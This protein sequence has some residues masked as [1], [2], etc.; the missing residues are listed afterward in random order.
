[1]KKT[2]ILL[3]AAIILC[4][5]ASANKEDNNIM[6]GQDDYKRLWSKVDSL[7]DKGLPASVLK[8]LDEIYLKA[9]KENEAAQFVKAVVFKLRYNAYKQDDSPAFGIEQLI[10]E[11]ETAQFPIKPVL[12]SMLADLYAQ[13]YNNNRWRFSERSRTQDFD[14]KDIRTWDLQSLVEQTII[15]HKKALENPEELKKIKIDL[16][17][18]VIYKGYEGRLFRP[19]L[20]DFLAHKA[21]DYFM[22]SEPD[23][24]HPAEQFNLNDERYFSPAEEFVKIKLSTAD[25]LSYK[26]YALKLLQDMISFH[27]ADSDLSPLTD[28]DL[29]RLDFV[30]NNAVIEN[31]EH[32]YLNTISRLEQKTISLPISTEVSYRIA[33]RSY[34]NSL[35]YIAGVSE[36]HRWDAKI[37]REMCE[38]IID[39]FP[40]SKGAQDC[41]SLISTIETK[42]MNLVYEEVNVPDKPFLGQLKFRNMKKVYFRVIKTSRQEIQSIRK[43][44]NEYYDKHEEWK[45]YDEILI[46][47]YNKKTPLHSFSYTLPDDGDFQ[48]HTAEVKV[49]GLSSGEYLIM[50]A[51]SEAF[52]YKEQAVCFAFT[53]SNSIS[54]IYR[55]DINRDMDF[56]VMHRETGKHLEA[57]SAKLSYQKYDYKLGKYV[58]MDGGI[59]KTD[60]QGYFQVKAPKEYRSFNLEFRYKNEVYYTGNDDNNNSVFYQ[61]EKEE[62]EILG[63]PVTTFFLDRAIYRPGQTLYFKGICYHANGKNTKILPNHESTVTLYD[64]N[65]QEVASVAVT[66]NEFGTFNGSFVLPNSGLNGQMSINNYY[67]SASFSVEDYK[68]PKF[69]VKIDK[70]KGAYRLNDQVSITGNAKAYS[71]ANIDGA[72]V[73]FRVVRKIN[74]PDWWWYY[75]GSNEQTEIL[76]GVVKTNEKGEFTIS[77]KALPDPTVSASSQAYFSYTVYADVTDINGETRSSSGIVRIGYTTLQVSLDIPDKLEKEQEN[78]FSISSANLDGEYQPAK[79]KLTIYR[80]KN[81]GRAFR[82]KLWDNPDKFLMS[83]EEFYAA[84]PHDQY[85]DEGDFHKWEKEKVSDQDFDTEANKK[86]AL[87]GMKAWPQGMYLAELI[88]K[89]KFGTEVKELRYFTLF[90]KKEAKL[91]YPETDWFVNLKY[92]AE[93][94]EKTEI[95][96]GSSLDSVVVLYEVEQ[97][98]KLLSKKIMVLNNEQKFLQENVTENF[99]GNFSI[100]YTFIK[101]NRLY[102]HDETIV[103]PYTNKELEITFETFR[104]KLQPGEAEE[105][106]IK[107]KGKMGDKVAAEMAATLYDASLDVFRPNNWSFNIYPTY[108]AILNWDN[109]GSG[110]STS[111][112]T[113]YQVGWY[114]TQSGGYRSYDSFNWFGYYYSGYDNGYDDEDEVVRSGGRDKKKSAKRLTKDGDQDMTTVTEIQY[115]T[116]S[117]NFSVE[118]KIEIGAKL[119]YSQEKEEAKKDSPK[120]DL[121]NIK[122]RTNFNET[123][124]FFPDL[125]TDSSGALVIKFKIPEALTRWKMLGFAHTRDLKFGLV[126]KELITQKELMVV[127]NAPRFFREG[128]KISFSSKITNL[129]DKDL[130][131]TVQLMLFDALTMKPADD[132]MGNSKAQQ[133]FSA[134]A[135]QSAGVFWDIKIPEGMQAVTY[136]VVAKAGKFSDGEEMTLPVLT[137][138]MLMTESMPMPIRSKQTKT[139]TLDKMVHNKSATLR[140]HKLTLEFTSQPAWYAIQALPYLMEYP[141]ECAEQ[142]FSRFYANSIATHI[143]N[144]DPKIK[145]V[146]DSWQ[147][148]TSDALLSNLEKNQELKSLMLEETP[149]VRDA[150]G[151][152]E[153]KKRIAVLFDL[154]RMS[155][156]LDRALE[157]ITR[158]Q[159]ANGA[160]PWFEGMPEDRYITQH[161]TTGL[162][163]LDHLGIKNIR[164]SSKTWKMAQDA[165]G[166]LDNRI[167]KDYEELKALEARKLI[168]LSDNNLSYTQI[169]YLYMRSFFRDVT[170]D[171][172]NQEAV[173]YFTRQSKKYWLSFN[174]YMQGMIALALSRNGETVVTADIIKSMREFA[175]ISDEMGMYW[176]QDYGYFWYQA[177]IETQSLMVEVFNEVAKD[178]KAVD[179]LKVWLIKNKQTTD[180]KTTKATADACYALLL[181]GINW[182]ASDELV[183]IKVGDM[184]IDPGKM[185]DV[186]VEAGTGYFKTSWN[187][188]EIKPEMGTV[189]LSKKD[190]GVSWGA[191][192]WQYFEQLDKITPHETPLKLKKQ[193]FL[194]K[195]T[196]TGPVIV[197]VTDKTELKPGDLIK[198]RIELRVDRTMEYV[199]MKDM[200]ASAFE[201][202]NVMSQYKY[203][204]GL[205][206]YESTRDAATNF[207]FGYLPKGTYVFQYPL[208]VTHDGD[209]SNGVTT[210]QCMYAPEFIS[211]SEGLRVK[212]GK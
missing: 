62:E 8:V 202:V 183:E 41:R 199:H 152:T 180:W 31:K 162:G 17:D 34:D 92:S 12:H 117:Y 74:F 6:L 204:D 186:K 33:Y 139:F 176:K 28:V 76:N 109:N 101:N 98:G 107:I 106:R 80:L 116:E 124:F 70:V 26:F 178:Q 47:H 4:C 134:K 55:T 110:F 127:P 181:T 49:P 93:P 59:F 16:Y 168:K 205:G 161:I 149:W 136:R 125:R 29:K 118:K 173:N 54:Y 30:F 61:Y 39:R 72:D 11:S 5:K 171:K 184:T 170:I 166:Y 83:R 71:G 197:P 155:M 84:F 195:N 88:S 212:V 185:P 64:V 15:Q 105:W 46:D 21:I 96:A 95:L 160:W 42:N 208:R 65:G 38:K 78:E 153:R 69:E 102:R 73:K 122:A 51:S 190:E 111:A 56:H 141:Y 108:Y 81:P 188:L 209:F 143:V 115:E 128:D 82:A 10:A 187:G 44:A 57:V 191:L 23:V 144:S 207:F 156:E 120:E 79:G 104:D 158:M 100:H 86:L 163:H 97:F 182:L 146:F 66:A 94:G 63:R 194:E 90:S 58:N 151:E 203:Q 99:R 77:F 32:L 201:P 52:T 45:E 13:Y 189:V 87:K 157:K 165:L 85:S 135:G 131:G 3:V 25:S 68:R 164:E 7:Q 36:D 112:G 179:D 210:I 169:Q 19:T 48:Q 18:E 211:H 37:A 121:G 130:S 193:L 113:L 147:N 167:R 20:Y 192:Y 159:K 138:R 91:P 137:N 75:R 196:A 148:I 206:Y 123:A 150:K 200:R 140:S 43:T 103:V 119:E 1:V 198:V 22:G 89:D 177:P 114:D 24:T 9:K 129:S 145:K 35:K 172:K 142:V 40:Q 14:P 174:R 50:A 60:K 53:R 175:I 2:A 133:S 154:N 27:L 67:G 132:I 126:E